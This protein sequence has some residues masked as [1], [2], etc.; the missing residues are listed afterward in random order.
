[1]VELGARGMDVEG[2]SVGIRPVLASGREREVRAPTG[3]LNGHARGETRTL[4][5]APSGAALERAATAALDKLNRGVLLILPDGRVAF[6]NRAAQGMLA[7]G[8]GIALRAGRLEFQARGVQTRFETFLERHADADGGASLVLTA[9]GP[10]QRGSYR[11]LVTPLESGADGPSHC[12]FVYEPEAGRCA[13]PTKVLAQLYGLTPG[14]ARLT[15]ELFLGKSLGDAAGAAG[16]TENT[17]R[18][19]LKRIFGKCGVGSQAELLQLLSLGP[20]TL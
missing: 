12:V 14:E 13:L 7:R 10:R 1:M 9:S 3:A 18:S 19:K 11:V 6:S 4:P 5:S 8:S 2:L 16:I 17:A 20:R 15:N